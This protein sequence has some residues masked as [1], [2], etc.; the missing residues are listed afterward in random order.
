MVLSP[1][2]E[3][4]LAPL[5]VVG[6]ATGVLLPNLPELLR[7]VEVLVLVVAG[8]VVVLAPA[9][10]VVEAVGLAPAVAVVEAVGLAPAGAEPVGLGPEETGAVGLEACLALTVGWFCCLN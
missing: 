2:A 4:V 9:V 7:P 1:V 8:P 10:A 6:G 3:E 5:V